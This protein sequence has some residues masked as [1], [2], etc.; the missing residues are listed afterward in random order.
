MAISVNVNG[1][2]VSLDAPPEMPLLWAIRDVLGMPGTKYGCGTGLCGACTVHLDGAAVPYRK[3]PARPS[4][5]SK[6]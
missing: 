2:D 4:S 6:G 3:R 5:R 1:R